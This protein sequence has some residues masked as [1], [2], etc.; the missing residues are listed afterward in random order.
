VTKINYADLLL[1]SMTNSSTPISS[2]HSYIASL[3]TQT[4]VSTAV[5][6]LVRLILL[7]CA[8]S[9]KS[10]H[11]LLGTSLTSLSIALISS[12]AQ[13]GG[14]AVREEAEEEWKSSTHTDTNSVRIIRPLKEVGMKECAL[15]AW[16]ADLKVVGQE[17]VPGAKQGIGGLTKGTLAFS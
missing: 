13:G 3:P 6:N 16:W 5:Q 10:S 1:S 8:S 9:T 11:L 4:A 2:L 15:W 14:F 17:N 7:H 12:I